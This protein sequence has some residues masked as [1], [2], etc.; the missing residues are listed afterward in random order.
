M[1]AITNDQLFTELNEEEQASL[2]G[3]HRCYYFW[4]WRIVR[5]GW[6]VFYR[7]VRLVRCY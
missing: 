7:Y 3:G 2:N 1:S 4:A 6:R 5:V